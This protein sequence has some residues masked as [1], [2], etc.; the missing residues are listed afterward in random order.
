LSSTTVRYGLWLPI[1]FSS[2]PD[3]PTSVRLGFQLCRLINK[4]VFTGL[5][6]QPNAQPPTWRT[7][8]SL[9][10]WNVTLDL[11]GLGDPA[12]SYATAGIDLEIIGAR[13]PHRHDKTETPRGEPCILRY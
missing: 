12:S 2:I 5:G 3:G 4:F 10:V 1:Q 13:K 9:L 11:S 7:M 8:V 6:C